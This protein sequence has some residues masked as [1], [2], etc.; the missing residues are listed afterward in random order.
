MRKVGLLVG[1]VSWT[2]G[3]ELVVRW[4]KV[5]NVNT[6]GTTGQLIPFVIGVSGLVEIFYRCVMKYRS[7]HE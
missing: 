7:G 3:T 5:S 2:V 4:N 1:V 6:I